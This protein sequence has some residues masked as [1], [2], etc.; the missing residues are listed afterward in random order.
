MDSRPQLVMDLASYP[1]LTEHV[2]RAV[3][4]G[5]VN[6]IGEHT[7]YNDGLALPF[8]VAAG[9]TVSATRLDGTT[10]EAV[11]QDLGEHDRFAL[12]HPTPVQGWPAFV[13]GAYA[14]LAALGLPPPAARVEISSDLP[15]GAG[16]SSS[17]ALEVALCLALVALAGAQPPDRIELARL[18]QRIEHHWLGAETGLLDQLASLSGRAG[19]AILID[20]RSLELEPLPL[21]LG[22]HRLVTMSSGE[23]RD[24]AASGYNRR[25]EECVEAA[26]R[27]GVES[28]RDALIQD[29]HMLPDVLAR[30]AHHVISENGRVLGAATA[31]RRRD[32]G[33]LGRLL[34]LSHASLRDDFEVSTPAIERTVRT[35]KDAGALGARLLGGGF[36]GHVLGLLPPDVVAPAGATTVAPGPGARLL[37]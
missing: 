8:A 10:V 18:G 24:N 20:F 15:R 2:A 25:R 21:D 22:A 9:V 27:M 34:D 16:L 31:L 36:G 13:R 5:R 35:L 17:A 14:E 1:T 28:L 19:H 4:P 12:G 33:R 26:H 11:A 3:A 32:F 30:R 29:L 23:P 37:A 6:L 7:D